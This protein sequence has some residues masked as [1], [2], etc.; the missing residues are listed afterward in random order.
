M[1]RFLFASIP[2]P[3]H[4]T[5]PLPFAA[6]LIDRGHDVLWYAGR[7]FHDRIAAVGAT[8]LPYRAATDWEGDPFDAFPQLRGSR[9][10]RAIGEGF[11]DVFVGEA[12]ARVADLRPV[13]A[14]QRIDAMLHDGL[15]IGVGMLS[16]LTGVPHATFGDGPLPYLEPDTPPFGPGLQPM[17]GPVGRLRNRLIGT[18]STR[19]I[20]GRAQQVYDRTRSDLGLPKDPRP[21]LDA[22]ASPMLHMQG[23]VP[24]FDYPRRHLPPTV[25]WVGALRPDPPRDW[26]PPSWWPR[27][28][29]SRRPVVHVTQGSIRPDMTELVVPTLRALA[30]EDMLVVVTTGGPDRVEVEAAYGGPLPANA[31]VTPFIP[32]DVMFRHA[33]VVVTNGGYTG[34]T[35]AL[36]HGLPLVQAGT[37]EE[38]TEIGARIRWS[39]VGLALRTS[40]PQPDKLRAGV[41]R[42]LAEPSFR[43]AAERV[44]AEMAP[45]DAGREGAVLLER[46]AATR[47][48]VSTP[49]PPMAALEADLGR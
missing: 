29:D 37:T 38:K 40:R 39:G 28:V 23:A 18:V 21:A 12:A 22:V 43:D 16:E 2:I 3:A 46:L 7:A 42:V 11:A 6:R 41:R 44:Q 30:G 32:Y 34:V 31:L 45:H 17:R 19:M 14:G 1:A 27:V 4:T 26:T 25:H 47:A 13:L 10:P 9:G 24:S 36:S 35:L 5:N 49:V 15:M 33:S 48:P 8:P 20:F